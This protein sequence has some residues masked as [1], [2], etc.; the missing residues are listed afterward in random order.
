MSIQFDGK[1]ITVFGG[2]GFIGKHL[3]SKLSK[4]NCSIEIVTR[5]SGNNKE[6]K[7]L[8]G[9]GQVKVKISNS[10]DENHLKALIKGS[11]IVINL[12]GILY[13]KKNQKF[14]NLHSHIPK[15]IA[16]VSKKVGVKNFLHLSSLGIDKNSFSKY[17]LSKLEGEK[18]IR[19]E[20]PDSLVYR[21]SVVFGDEDSFINLFS[22]LSN[23]SPVMPIIG[24][25]KIDFTAKLSSKL[26]FTE[27]VRFQPIYVGDLVEFI[28]KTSFEKA[29]T[30][31]LAGPNIISFK[32]IMQLILST[33]KKKRILLPVPLFIA[34]FMAFFME[35]L[36]KPIL[37]SDQV[38]LLK[39][40]NISQKGF[41]N[42]KK[43]IN[44]PK[45]LEIVISTYIK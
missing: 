37:T 3:V 27:G 22:K 25:P 15:T 1:K 11:D 28:I 20:F 35:K 19:I 21:P 34:K 9:L 41:E 45:S 17:A 10:F 38:T 4:Y 39:N 26:K 24:T 42:L 31:D 16:K 5:K 7:F 40:D 2:S 18:N 12:I 6:L 13:E 44:F 32:K 33:K 8:G 29:K 30:Y 14:E 23:F 36:P 43:K